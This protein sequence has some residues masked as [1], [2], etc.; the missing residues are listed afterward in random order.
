VPALL[1]TGLTIVALATPPAARA[2]ATPDSVT[3][4][5]EAALDSLWASATH[6]PE[7]V[8]DSL[9]P[10]R[11]I[12][13][14]LASLLGGDPVEPAAVVEPRPGLSVV[15]L[16]TI[17]YNPAY[18]VYFGGSAS[19]AGWLGE[20][21]TTTLSIFALN[22]TYSTSGQLSVMLRSDAW[23][24]GNR[25]NLKG[26]WRYLD[27]S[28]PTYGLGPIENQTG[29]YPMEFKHIRFH[30]AAYLPVAD[31]F[32]AGLGYKLDVHREILDERARAGEATPFTV[33]SGGTVAKT[34]S[35]GFDASVLVDSR[36][37]PVNATNGFYWNASFRSSL[38]AV[39][40]DTDWQELLSEFRLYPR[41]PRGGRNVL[42]IW[43][44]MWFTFGQAPYLDLPSIGWDKFGKTGRGYV[45]GRI[46]AADL[47]YNE[48]EYRMALTR[49]G[50]LGGVVFANFTSATPPGRG[51]GRLDPGLGLGLR[52]KFIKR[53]GTNLTID[54]GWGNGNSKGL[55]LGTQEIF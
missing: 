17:G 19:A 44:M 14:L 12:M 25:W 38:T 16:P 39:G 27:T 51:F 15:V 52:I 24:P 1:M 9:P 21:K 11:D 55:Y 22:A 30:Q 43:S 48:V 41:V 26:D 28:Q 36:D 50:L 49:D 45:Q 37:N 53:T 54:Y 40:S 13:D 5:T 8:P 6:R 34:V 29:R 10:Q 46:R 20:P 42:A 23:T 35:S 47:V 3:A 32:Y 33:Y 31:P 7:P 4:R 18:G 2:Q